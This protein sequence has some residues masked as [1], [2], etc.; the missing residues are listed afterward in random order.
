MIR[1]SALLLSALLTA[2][3][4]AAQVPAKAPVAAAAARVTAGT[5]KVDPAHTQVIWSVDHFGFSPLYGMFGEVTG[6]L[7]LDPARLQD[8]KLNIEIP[9]SGLTVTSPGFARHLATPDLFDTAKFPTARFVSTSIRPQGNRAVVT[10]DLTLHGVTKPVT[11]QT[12]LYGAGPNP[13][14]QAQ[15]VGFTATTTIKRS[16]WGLGYGV[17]AVGDDTELRITAAFEKAG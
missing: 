15:T 16:E 13:R 7:Q 6:T 5:Y 4:V 3:P 12:Q 11:L 14:T 10:G 9:M 2:A 8:A 1:T 17:P